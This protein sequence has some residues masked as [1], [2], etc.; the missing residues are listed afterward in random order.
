M[1]RPIFSQLL[2]YDTES[3]RRQRQT[4][5][6]IGQRLNYPAKNIAYWRLG[7][8]EI[9]YHSFKLASP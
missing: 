3:L 7:R 6:D 8:G 5:L 1:N 9:A 2:K 4:V